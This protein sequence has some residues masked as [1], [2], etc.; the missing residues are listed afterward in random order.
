MTHVRTAPYYP[1]ANGKMGRWN[2][3]IKESR[4]RSVHEQKDTDALGKV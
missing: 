2:K 1:H 4:P 3:S